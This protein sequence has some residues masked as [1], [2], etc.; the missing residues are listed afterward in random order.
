[1]TKSLKHVVTLA[2]L[3]IL[4]IV[5][6][7]FAADTSFALTL[8][9]HKF[10]PSELTIPANTKVK[11]SVKNL[12]KETAEFMS[13][14]FKGGKVI[15]GGKEASFF[16]GPLKSGNYEFHDEYHEAPSKGRLTVK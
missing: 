2:A 8:K 6:Q 14:D 3:L 1:M 4:P 5:N 9:D 16:I 12:D 7:A 11:I 10:S 13:D 15:E